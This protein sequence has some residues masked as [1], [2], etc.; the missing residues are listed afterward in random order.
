MI[1]TL[2]NCSEGFKTLVKEMTEDVVE[3][4]RKLEFKVEPEDKTELLHSHDKTLTNEEP[5]L[6]DEQRKWLLEMDSTPGKGA[7]QVAE[8][9]TKDLEYYIHLVA[10]AV[11]GFGST[12]SSFERSSIVCKILLNSLHAA[13]K[14]L[15]KGRVNQCNKLHCCL[16]FR[17]CHSHPS[18]Q[19]PPA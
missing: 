7:I 15:M 2:L 1:L 8:M 17:N 10:K 14:S 12:D 19:Q 18:L 16:I 13:E 4:A 6:M 9:I 11:A 3:M 5:L